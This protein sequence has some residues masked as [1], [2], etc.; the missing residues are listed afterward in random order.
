M[1]REAGLRF[2]LSKKLKIASGRSENF[3]DENKRVE[4]THSNDRKG[5]FKTM[6]MQR[7]LIERLFLGKDGI[8]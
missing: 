5:K 1:S 8:G 6:V 3:K 2:K 4:S 7:R